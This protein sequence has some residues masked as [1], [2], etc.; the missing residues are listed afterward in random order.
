M[1]VEKEIQKKQESGNK[2][3]RLENALLQTIINHSEI[4]MKEEVIMACS[5][6][7]SSRALFITGLL[8]LLY[9]FF[10]VHS[11]GGFLRL[12]KVITCQTI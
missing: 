9:L 2:S 3:A 10:Y 4:L 12:G 5:K 1:N 8:F 11:T 7:F 6:A